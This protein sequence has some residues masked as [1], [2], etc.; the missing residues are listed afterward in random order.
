MAAPPERHRLTPRTAQEW[1]AVAPQFVGIFGLLLQLVLW[2][3]TATINGGHG[4]FEP[5]M[6]TAFGGLIV[7]GQGAE[8]VVASRRPPPNP[9]QT[10][11]EG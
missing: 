2:G 8:A 10:E 1:A 9:E 6:L 4:I 11:D 5:A 7:V 3:V